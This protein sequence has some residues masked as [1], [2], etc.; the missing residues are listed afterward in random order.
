MSQTTPTRD[1][2]LN[3]AH[4]F[5]SAYNQWTVQAIMSIRSP[6]CIHYTLPASLRVPPRP[7][8]E[9]AAFMEPMLAVFR[10]VHFS[11][12]ADDDAVVDVER[13]QVVLHCRNRADTDAGEYANE[14]MFSL[15]ISEDGTKIDRI[16]E[17]I[18]AAY[19]AEFKARIT[20]ARESMKDDNAG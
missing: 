5:L 8:D 9:Y 1:Q 12:V 7:N 6:I 20:S 17:F 19:T 13:R 2:L 15:T 14:Y 18:D 4:G 11:M 16:V 3:T 10:S